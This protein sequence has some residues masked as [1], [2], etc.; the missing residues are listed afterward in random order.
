MA[1]KD[2][3][4]LLREFFGLSQKDFATSLG[5]KYKTY[6][7]YESEDGDPQ[8]S[9]LMKAIE[10]FNVAPNW[11]LTGEGEMFLPREDGPDAGVRGGLASDP[12]KLAAA[13][14]LDGLDEDQ[15]KKAYEYLSD[16]KQLSEFLKEKGA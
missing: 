11:L 16:Q 12:Q 14:L 13:K 3:L 9:F 1:I 4:R 5:V 8:V 6:W 10:K 7:R 15:I 2:R